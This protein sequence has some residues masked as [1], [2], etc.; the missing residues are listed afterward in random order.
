MRDRI[1]GRRRA[2]AERDTGLTARDEHFE[3]GRISGQ[4]AERGRHVDGPVVE[5][6]AVEEFTVVV[7]HEQQATL[8]A[9]HVFEHAV[10]V[11][12]DHRARRQTPPLHVNFPEDPPAF[13]KAIDY[14][15]LRD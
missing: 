6:E 4:I 2:E 9:E 1:G 7:Q 13:V 14:A 12:I 11:E 10:A 3:A 8:R 15:H 5:L